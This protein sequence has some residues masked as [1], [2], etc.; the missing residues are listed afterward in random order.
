MDSI[1]QCIV[2]RAS[3]EQ[4]IQNRLKRLN[5]RKLQIQECKVQK[6]KATD[7]SLGDINFSGIVSDK[8]NDQGLENQGNTSRDESS[9]SRNECNDKSTSKDDTDIK[10]SYD[11]KPM[12]EVPYTAEYNVFSVETQHSEKPENMNDT[13][14]MEK[15]DS[16]TTPDSLDMCDN[17]NQADQN[18][19][20]CGD[21]RVVLANLIANLKHDIDEKKD[22]K[23]IKESKCITDSR[24]ERVQI[25][26]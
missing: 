18:A 6:V 15:V 12:A 3:H 24:I 22:S 4:E 14:L 7:A 10:P 21:E 20:A 26:S 25:Y 13:S 17:D 5:K 23:A 16:N 9:R 11:T 8:G 1:E 19:E 2:K